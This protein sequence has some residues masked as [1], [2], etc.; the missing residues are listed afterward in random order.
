MFIPKSKL[1]DFLQKHVLLANTSHGSL[2][3]L[4]FLHYSMW[5]T[6]VTLLLHAR[7]YAKTFNLKTLLSLNEDNMDYFIQCYSSS[8][9]KELLS[10]CF[11]WRKRGQRGYLNKQR[12]FRPGPQCVPPPAHAHFYHS[13]FKVTFTKAENCW[14]QNS[15]H[16][17]PTSSHESQRRF[18]NVS[19]YILVSRQC[20]VFI[21]P[22]L[23]LCCEAECY[24][25]TIVA[26]TSHPTCPSY[27]LILTHFPFCG[28]FMFLLLKS[29]RFCCYVTFKSRL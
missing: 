5:V 12:R 27:N 29:G 11:R 14:F 2:F 6:W 25:S 13:G 17:N 18:Q 20:P 7:H 10:P 9:K 23:N 16:P 26:T 24:F 28:G 19:V 4:G 22:L 15:L 21:S 8:E 1:W 3:E